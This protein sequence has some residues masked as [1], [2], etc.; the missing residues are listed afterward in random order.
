M[1][2]S[3]RA[4]LA[5]VSIS[6]VLLAPAVPVG[7]VVAI[8]CSDVHIVWTRGANLGLDGLDWQK[9]VQ[10]PDDG[11]RARIAPPVTV[12]D[13]QLGDPGFGGFSYQS[14]DTPALIAEGLT[15]G[16]SF[17]PYDSSVS[18][19]RQELAAYLT[20]RQAQ[21]AN[22]TY[23]LGGYSEGADVIGSGLVDLPQAVRDRIASRR[24]VRRP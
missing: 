9:F 2:L 12:S 1:R 4:R 24:S 20:D 7:S 13:Y 10:D 18:T 23:V 22:E 14:V 8:A 5:R 17:G 16:L 3:L 19:G 21:C 6:L 15:G 11:L